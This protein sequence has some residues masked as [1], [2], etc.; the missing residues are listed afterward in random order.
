MAQ[1]LGMAIAEA[2]TRK[3]QSATVMPPKVVAPALELAE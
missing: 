3:V 1:G 2:A